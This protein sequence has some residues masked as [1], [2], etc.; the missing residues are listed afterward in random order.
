M[1]KNKLEI[2]PSSIYLMHKYWGK[3]PSKD[4][5]NIIEKYTKKDNLLLDPFSGFGGL[6]I[7]G[8]LLERNVILN[9]LNPVANFISSTILNLNIDIQLF[10][11]YYKNIREKYYEFSN[12]WYTFNNDKIITILRNKNDIPL[13]LKLYNKNTKKMFEYKLSDLEKEKFIEE[14]KNI[15]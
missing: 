10:E 12:K 15:K 1:K 7:E 5:R 8:V 9:D 14:E 11:N 2:T 13:K 3:K 6:G 4:L